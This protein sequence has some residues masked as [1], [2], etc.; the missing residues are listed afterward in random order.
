M[1]FERIVD[2]ATAAALRLDW[3]R[4]HLAPVSVYG[5]RVFAA[6]EPFAPQARLAAQASAHRIAALASA[7]DDAL[8]DAVRDVLRTT[9]DA[10][11]A[12]ARASMGDHLSDVH[13]L[14]LMRFADAVARID[15]ICAGVAGIEPMAGDALREVARALERG[16]TGTSGFY[17]ADDFDDGLAR[18]RVALAGA[19]AEYDAASGRCVAEIMGA[20]H[21]DDLPEDEFIVM[22]ADVP[23]ALPQ[24]V[25]VVRETPTYWL[26]AIELDDAARAALERRDAATAAHAN[27]EERVRAQLSAQV[28]EHADALEALASALGERDVL[29][30]QVRFARLQRCCAPEVVADTSIDAEGAR[31]S[32]LEAALARE[33]RAYTPIALRLDDVAVLTGP[34]MGGKSVCLQTC[35][36]LAV[37][38]S[39]GLPVPAQRAR[40]GIFESIAWL[41]VGG[42]GEVGGLLSS[43]AREVVRLRDLL[44]RSSERSLLLVDEF[45]RTT[46]PYEGKALLIGLIERLRE[47]RVRALIATHLDG[48]ARASGAVHYAVRG[49][50]GVL[51]KAP[52]GNLAD[53]LATL[54]AS[55]DYSVQVVGSEEIPHTDAIALASLLGLDDRLIDAA[56][57][58]LT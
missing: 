58:A 38:A 29:V 5:E 1:K 15:A 45:A 50:R 3:F 53:A 13:L 11:A 24:G 30:A 37:L 18:A 35:G 31:F 14:E 20:L 49:L 34:N 41:G 47:R 7:F 19:Q 51:Q 52:S 9:P 12:I 43:F 16:R 55:M 25:R 2:A 39:F 36:A 27:A 17:L 48:I 21:R 44:D 26:C 33:G 57:N 40:V 54:A 4:D 32:P 6:I 56:R 22:R 28:R 42:D 23:G 8:I 46:T 10:L